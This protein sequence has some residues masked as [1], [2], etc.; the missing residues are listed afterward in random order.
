MLIQNIKHTAYNQLINC[1]NYSDKM[2]FTPLSFCKVLWSCR[3]NRDDFVC[4]CLSQQSFHYLD[5]NT[6][7]KNHKRI[8]LLARS[9]VRQTESNECLSSSKWYIGREK[10]KV[11]KKKIAK[12]Y[13]FKYYQAMSNKTSLRFDNR[14]NLILNQVVYYNTAGRLL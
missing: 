2:I 6:I 1:K 3:H 9:I 11:W 14:S 4:L 8:N 10:I 12:V 13:K 5:I 7:F